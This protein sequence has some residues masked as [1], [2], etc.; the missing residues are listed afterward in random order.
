MREDATGCDK[1]ADVSVC[2]VSW[3]VADDLRICLRSLCEQRNPPSFEVIVAD[4]A[5]ADG[6]PQM[7]AADFPE[8]RLIANDA[9]LGFARG[10]N[11]GMAAAC[12]RYLML[13]NP[14]T[15][16]PPEAL[17][18]L[19]EVADANPDAGI[20]APKL[21]NP[22]GTLQYSCR[23]FP[24]VTAAIFRHTMFGR[25]LPGARSASY[26]IMED[27]DHESERDVD[28]VSGACML[29]RREALEQVGPL[30]QRFQWGSEDVDWCMRMHRAGW[31]VLYT[32]I[33]AIVHAIG[34]S[35]D[36]AVIPTIFRSHRGMYLLYSKHFAHNPL[37]R[38][39]IWAGVWVRAGLLIVSWRL[40]QLRAL[41]AA[42][43]HPLLRGG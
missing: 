2:I 29:V 9:N 20:V 36:Q 7:L 28:W 23:R 21:L 6:T 5:S 13:L 12:G 32:P 33:T 22:D 17:R 3:N 43:L 4:N 15:V 1:A 31:R 37:T 25:L 18:R 14:D 11:Q 24:T 42:R 10:T 39:V 41:L 27:F 34:R 16:V 30:D 38:V 8:V 40:R 35:S 26:Y 19:V